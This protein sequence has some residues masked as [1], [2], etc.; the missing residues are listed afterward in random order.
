MP[1]PTLLASY[2][3]QLAEANQ[4]IERMSE[5][6]RWYE[7]RVKKWQYGSVRESQ[8]AR[9]DLRLDAGRRAREELDDT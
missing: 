4:R 2:R 3:Q 6:L 7:V 1:D 8:N 5:A 9:Y